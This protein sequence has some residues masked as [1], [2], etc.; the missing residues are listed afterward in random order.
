MTTNLNRQL[1][2][3]TTLTLAVSSGVQAAFLDDSKTSLDSRT[4][5][6]QN[7]YRDGSGQNRVEESA[8]G[9]TFR[10]QS[11]YTEGDIGLGLD[12]A[13]M[14]G[15]KLDSGPQRSG[16]GLLPRNAESRPGGP[17]YARESQD[18]YSKLALTAKLR[19]YQDTQVLVGTINPS[20]GVL[21]PSTTR[22]FPQDFRGTQ[23]TN[24]SISG[25]TLRAGRLDRARHRDS[26]DYQGIGIAYANGQ[27][28]R[29]DN[30]DFKYA[31]ADYALGKDVV[32]SYNLGELEDVYRQHF[33]GIKGKLPAGPGRLVSDIRLFASQ[34]A[35]AGDAGTIDNRVYSGLFG[36]E[37]NG[38]TLQAGY[39]KVDGKGAYPQLENTA[40]YLHTEMML[41]NFA[42]QNQASWLARYDYNFAAAGL[43]GLM[44]T[45]RYVKSDNAQ[46]VGVQQDGRERELDTD[47]GY[48]VQS[49]TFKDLAV[50]WRHGVLRSNYQRNSDQDRLI[51]DY[52][53]KF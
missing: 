48:V 35:G 9:L 5:Y 52:S 3:L 46:V 19:L 51:V 32:L 33:V 38:H 13:L 49:G 26:T 10:F 17:S 30:R 4:F 41:T 8:Q 2:T 34:E 40:T 20:L 25:L 22:L 36:Y 15:F 12:A 31:A 53:F 29:T 1:L 11:G 42:K 50:R 21:Q 7:D 28:P 6:F 27:Y 37:W 18:E 24:T 44:L 23:V 39:Q 16:S 47:I 14:Y 43:P 45:V